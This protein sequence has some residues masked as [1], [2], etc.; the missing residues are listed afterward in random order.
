MLKNLQI[1]FICVAAILSACVRA[2]PVYIEN[3]KKT[4]QAAIQL[5]I[6]RFNREDYDAIYDD[7]NDVFKNANSKENVI[8]LMKQT[9]E[10]NGEIIEVTDQLVKVLP[11]P[12]LQVRAVYNIKCE[13]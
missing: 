13:K 1:I 12:P 6:V 9:R 5:F 11:G 8:P 2:R 10:Q 4:A 7:A 3:E